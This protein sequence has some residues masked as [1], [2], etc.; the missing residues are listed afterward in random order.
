[1][2]SFIASAWSSPMAPDM[3]VSITPG[4]IALIRTPR[5]A[6]SIA[7]LLV[8]PIT[9]WFVARYEVRPA[10]P[11]AAKR[12]TVDDRAAALRA[13]LA[14]FMLHAGPDT[15]Q[16]HGGHLVEAFRRLIGEVARETDD[17]GVVEG[18]VQPTVGGNG[19]LDHGVT[20]DSSATSQVTQIAW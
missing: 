20:C 10:C 6:Q 18:H 12:R 13:H 16:I 4:H 5:G 17:A 11:K 19:V 8:R 14:E 9:Q 2:I 3:G 15:A 7:A 1:M